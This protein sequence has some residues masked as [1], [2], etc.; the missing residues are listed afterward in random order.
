MF[1]TRQA[2][3]RQMQDDAM[4]AGANL[5]DP[6]GA[7]MMYASSLSG[8][9]YGQGLM[10]IASMFGGGDP[11]VQQQQA[12][13]EIMKRFPNPQ[14]PEDFVE[15]S[16]ALTGA[17]LHSYASKAMDLANTT[18][19]SMPERKILTDAGGFNR[20]ADTGERVFPDATLKEKDP[21]MHQA[22]DGFWYYASGSEKGKRVFPEV[23][24]PEE[25]RKIKQAADGYYYYDDD[26]T[27][28]FPDVK[29]KDPARGKT[30]A[31][32]GYWYWDDT[33]TRVFPGITKPEQAQMQEAADGF[34]YYTSGDKLGQR[35][36]PNVV[37]ADK[38]RSMHQAVDDFW[39]F[40]DDQTRVFPGVNKPT[41]QGEV[42]QGADGFKYWA[43][44]ANDG[45]RVF[46]DVIKPEEQPKTSKGADGYLYYEGG[47]NHAK[48][49]YPDVMIPAETA[50]SYEQAALQIL[51]DDPKFQALPNDIKMEKYAENYRIFHPTDPDSA[52]E[53]SLTNI[54]NDFIAKAQV[55]LKSEGNE[56]WEN[57]GTTQGDIDFFNFKKNAQKEIMA[58]NTDLT[59]VL[60]QYKIWGDRS[61]PILKDMDAL[62]NLQHQ[63][64]LARDENNAQAW[65]AAQRGFVALM[66]DSNLSLAE[67]ATVKNAG[68]LVRKAFNKISEWSI[69]TPIVE[70]I[71][72]TLAIM[73]HMEKIIIHRYN[74]T[75]TKFNE[76]MTIAGSTPEILDAISGE[77]MELLITS[78]NASP[79]DIEAEIARRA[80]AAAAQ[81]Q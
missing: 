63:I 13:D 25:E 27:R 20:Y 19:A 57:E 33:Q 60:A 62:S 71:E 65:Q 16:N 59:S 52:N 39:Y 37:I 32:D 15:I 53:A 44:G 76:S 43:G 66:K 80:A 64:N 69:G 61:I 29:A 70:H 81:G 68:N 4:K 47:P 24:K 54:R 28:V 67:V 41:E 49:V 50:N 6:I 21:E 22:A 18:R 10:G 74:D 3:S 36:L 2:I 48:R 79:A 17:G 30:Q 55:K 34:L 14:T 8:D 7:G 72:E 77:K 78:A 31:A 51:Q 38:D 75:H 46:P 12:L 35:V 11:R 40:D 73:A 23:N 45:K 1:D 56:N 5:S 26:K 42:K 9:M 58:G